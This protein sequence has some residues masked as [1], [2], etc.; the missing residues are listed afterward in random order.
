MAFVPARGAAEWF[1]A[2]GPHLPCF[3]GSAR[4]RVQMPY[5]NGAEI[6]ECTANHVSVRAFAAL[7][8][9]CPY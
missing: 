8:S 5:P 4:P 7:S 1:L 2:H 9:V 3:T 6:R